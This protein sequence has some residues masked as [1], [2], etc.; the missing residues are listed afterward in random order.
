MRIE[1]F[2]GDGWTPFLLEPGEELAFELDS[3]DSIDLDVVTAQLALALEARVKDLWPAATI[4]VS[5]QRSGETRL[6]SVTL[7]EADLANLGEL[8][9]M[10][11]GDLEHPA[12]DGAAMIEGE[13]EGQ[14]A[15]IV[16]AQPHTWRFGR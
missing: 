16:E 9:G 7:D 6:S 3:P 11:P 10:E 8:V 15:G 5:P 2:I 1:L 13:I 14:L 4:V 12:L